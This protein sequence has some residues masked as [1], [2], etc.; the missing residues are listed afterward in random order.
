MP[1]SLDEKFD[2]ILENISSRNRSY[3]SKILTW[4]T[5]SRR[6]LELEEVEAI[7]GCSEA[8]PAKHEFDRD[9]CMQDGQNQIFDVCSNLVKLVEV[10]SFRVW[11]LSYGSNRR[12]TSPRIGNER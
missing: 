4:L 2:Q 6:P 5:F 10:P 12:S 9:K 7:V 3:A 8:D 1:R 11:S